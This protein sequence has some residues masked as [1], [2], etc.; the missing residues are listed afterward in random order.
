M[1]IKTLYFIEFS[2]V[3]VEYVSNVVNVVIFCEIIFSAMNDTSGA[4]LFMFFCLSK[5]HRYTAPNRTKNVHWS[6]RSANLAITREI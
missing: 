1:R 6:N 3:G 5:W 2:T 4:N